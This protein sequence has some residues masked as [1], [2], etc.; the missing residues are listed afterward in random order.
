V[1]NILT[2]LLSI[3]F[4]CGN[5][6]SQQYFNNIYDF[7][8]NEYNNFNHHVY[9][10]EK[11]FFAVGVTFNN[12]Y[13]TLFS[14]LNENGDTIWTNRQQYIAPDYGGVVG[15]S[16]IQLQSGII[17]A[18]GSMYDSIE[19]ATDIFL[20]AFNEQGDSLWFQNLDAGFNDRPAKM[21][22][23]DDGGL[24][25]LGYYYLGDVDS[26]RIVI[27]KTDSL[28]NKLWQREYGQPNSYNF[29]Y[30]WYKTDDG[31]YI[32][33]GERNDN[34]NQNINLLLMKLDRSFNELWAKSYDA[35]YLDF[36]GAFSNLVITEKA[37]Y[38]VGQQEYV[39]Q[40][41]GL[42]KIKGIILKTDTAGNQIWMKLEDEPLRNYY[43]R[44]IVQT[45][46]SEFVILS[47]ITND[48]GLYA[49][50]RAL[51][52]KIDSAGNH[53]WKREITH[54]NDGRY[55][56]GYPNH[57]TLNDDGGFTFSGYIQHFLP[58]RNDAW[59]VKTDSCGYTEGDVSIAQIQLVSIQ[60]STV[61][62]HNTSP[63]YC[64]W[65][66]Y[67]GNGDSSSVRHPQYTYSDTGTYTIMLITQ[68]G[69]E[70]DTAYLTIHIGDSTL[71]SPQI[72]SIQP[73]LKL[74]PNPATEYIILSGFIPQETGKA[75]LA[76][77][78]M[79]GKLIKQEPVEQGAINRS[80]GIKEFSQGVYAYKVFTN[81]KIINTGRIFI[82]P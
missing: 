9:T 71:S 68:A 59:L 33:A 34:N 16:S 2:T 48:T 77:Y 67:F 3:F 26:S 65:Q 49:L 21:L 62:L 15:F 70:K 22:L 35:G 28:G 25:V 18:N 37:Y 54:Y 57:I 58:T 78:D 38:L 56:M 8:N 60:D 46:E 53:L 44:G 61:T 63:Q 47:A 81:E 64:K 74:Y 79:Q 72:T 27:I 39:A 4:L 5:T 45:A 55:E 23:D 41:S 31:G 73:R 52:I 20:H 69:N 82:E 24:L 36:A 29:C 13:Y 40:S 80:I 19:N 43:Y 32:L 42:L 17:V 51:L 7:F 66:W 12:S 30:N 1:K 50:S 76:F 6:Y 10:V 11:N 75:V 14:M